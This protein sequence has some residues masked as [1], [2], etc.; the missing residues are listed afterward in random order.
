MIGTGASAIQVVPAIA[1][2]V[3]TVGIFQRSAPWIGPFEKLRLEVP[4]P[5]Q[6]PF[7]P[8]HE[9]M[10]AL[11]LSRGRPAHELAA[12][13]RRAFSGIVAGN[14]KEQ[15]VAAIARHGPYE[16]RGDTAIMRLLDRL[17]SAFVQQQRMKLPGSRYKPCYR[18]VA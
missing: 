8:T 1:D 16:L 3:E 14:V 5:L 10:R 17:L 7:V 12:D 4:P 9:A 18:L 2:R 15:G 13:L 11:N 6:Q